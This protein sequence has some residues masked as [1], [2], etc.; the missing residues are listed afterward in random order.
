MRNSSDMCE[1]AWP[2]NH[3]NNPMVFY[4]KFAGNHQVFF[5]LYCELSNKTFI[6][7]TNSQ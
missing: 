3:N 2:K 5:S 4:L 7:S 1:I 6:M